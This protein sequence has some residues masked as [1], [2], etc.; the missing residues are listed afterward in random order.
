MFKIRVAAT[1]SQSWTISCPG[2]HFLLRFEHEIHG[3]LVDNILPPTVRV[4]IAGRE[5]DFMPSP[6]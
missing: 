1:E 2:M 5:G 3:V 4:V 6:R